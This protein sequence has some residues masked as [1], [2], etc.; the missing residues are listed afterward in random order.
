LEFFYC[1]IILEY[2][3]ADALVG[4]LFKFEISQNAE[5]IKKGQNFMTIFFFVLTRK[6]QLNSHANF[7]ENF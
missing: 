3:A 2:L 4:K 5:F 6:T 1:F 7:I